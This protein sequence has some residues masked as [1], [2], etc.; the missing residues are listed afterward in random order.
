MSLGNL[1]FDSAVSSLSPYLPCGRPYLA[2]RFLPPSRPSQGSQITVKSLLSQGAQGLGQRRE[3]GRKPVKAQR[4][5]R[6]PEMRW[7]EEG[8]PQPAEVPKTEE[9]RTV[10]EPTEPRSQ[11]SPAKFSVH[12]INQEVQLFSHFQPRQVRVRPQ[13]E[14]KLRV[15]LGLR[16]ASKGD[17]L[18]GVKAAGR[19]SATDR[20]PNTSIL[21][22]GSRCSYSHRSAFYMHPEPSVVL[23]RDARPGYSPARPREQRSS[24]LR[25]LLRVKPVLSGKKEM[26]KSVATAS[27]TVF[28]VAGLEEAGKKAYHSFEKSRSSRE[29]LG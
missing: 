9:R 18:S 7:K 25:S 12:N 11:A 29:F 23:V 13:S 6:M 26:R 27:F 16:G 14:L 15:E 24:A 17:L 22:Q 19:G 3:E 10:L 21:V 28:E 8:L 1:S 5:I 20:R 2:Q 4:K